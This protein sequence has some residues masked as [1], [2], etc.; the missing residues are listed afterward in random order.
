MPFGV[1]LRGFFPDRRAVEIDAQRI[2]GLC[3]PPPRWRGSEPGD[4]GRRTRNP[5]S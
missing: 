3:R 1:Q 4:D 2:F 5:G